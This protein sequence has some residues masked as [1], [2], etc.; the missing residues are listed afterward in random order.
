M[1]SQSAV[2]AAEHR[3]QP[4]RPHPATAV[5]DHRTGGDEV[6]SSAEICGIPI[7]TLARRPPVEVGAC[8]VG[9]RRVNPGRGRGL[10]RDGSTVVSPAR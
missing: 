10:D 7:G 4:D 2:A 1:D 5:A 8:R 6:N 9:L 3:P